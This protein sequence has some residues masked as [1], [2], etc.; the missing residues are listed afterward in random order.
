MH[1]IEVLRRPRDAGLPA[2]LELKQVYLS[3]LDRETW[4]SYCKRQSAKENPERERERLNSANDSSCGKCEESKTSYI[5]RIASLNGHPGTLRTG[6]LGTALRDWSSGVFP[7]A[8]R[9]RG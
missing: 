3:R 8:F 9:V 1:R 5:P 2:R 4:G 7:M 6:V